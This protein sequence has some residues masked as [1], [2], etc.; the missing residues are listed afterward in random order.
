MCPTCAECTRSAA[1]ISSAAAAM[2]VATS[3]RNR[4]RRGMTGSE[5]GSVPAGPR[6]IDAT[7][8]RRLTVTSDDSPNR[9]VAP[10]AWTNR[11]GYGQPMRNLPS[12]LQSCAAVL[13]YFVVG[14][15]SP[16]S[17]KAGWDVGPG[18]DGGLTN[19]G[20]AP[21]PGSGLGPS[22]MLTTA[23]A[24]ATGTGPPTSLADASGP[25]ADAGSAPSQAGAGQG[26]AGAEA[27]LALT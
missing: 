26:G 6:N 14:C 4:S 1:K 25:P 8:E 23:D 22:L 15:G 12:V 20:A 21:P 7:G 19:D 17:N 27:S 18:A 10:C 2:A 9:A 5:A 16:G 3:R 11:V 24:G 13:V